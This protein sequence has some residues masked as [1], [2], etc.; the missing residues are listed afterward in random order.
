MTHAALPAAQAS[1]ELLLTEPND[2]LIHSMPFLASKVPDQ[3]PYMVPASS[4]R[5]RG[6]EQANLYKEGA[7]PLDRRL[8]SNRPD[9]RATLVRTATTG[10]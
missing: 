1:S 10:K 5:Q 4:S 7:A 9:S 3:A 8:S 6:T 2:T